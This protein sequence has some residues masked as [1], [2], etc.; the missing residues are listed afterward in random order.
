[1]YTVVILAEQ[2]LSDSDAAE[3]VSLHEEIEEPRHYHVVIPCDDAKRL[4]QGTLGTLAASEAMAPPPILTE[5][6]DITATQEAIDRSAE[7]AVDASVAAIKA[8]GQAATGEF[9]RED[10]I[11]TL[12][13]VAREHEAA[14]VIVM[15]QQHVIAEFL[16]V[17][18]ASKA[19]RH[20][21][22][23]VLHLLEHEP[24]DIEAG[25]GQGITGM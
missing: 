25:Y 21:G 20:L 6:P 12:E 15:T 9:D 14:E 3:V 11:E 5:Q 17:D 8:H 16:H 1:V 2:A 22:V 7:N 19:R 13:R 18:W 24:L 10:P 4:V 23:P